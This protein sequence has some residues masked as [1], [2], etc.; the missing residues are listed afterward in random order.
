[1]P[2]GAAATD[3]Q[4]AEDFEGLAAV[5]VWDFGRSRRKIIAQEMN[6]LCLERIEGASNPHSSVL[7]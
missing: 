1:M 6:I 2:N 7:P 5:L 4:A 3:N